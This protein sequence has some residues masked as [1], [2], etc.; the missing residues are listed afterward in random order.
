MTTMSTI[1]IV[2]IA[3]AILFDFLNGIHDSSNIV[4]TMISSRAFSPRVALGVTAV[5]EFAGPFI[6]GVAVATTIGDEVVVAEAITMNVL[7]AALLSAIIWNLLTWFFGIPSSS[8]HALIGGMVGAVGVGA[9]WDAIKL[10]GIEKIL[11]ALFISP[12]LGLALGYLFTKLVF[13]FARGASPKIN[14]FFRRSQIVT[15]IAL[16]LSHGT[17]DAQKTMGLI[18]LGLVTAGAIPRFEVPLWV[19]AVSAGAISLGTALGGWRLIKTLGA[20][21]YKIRPVHGFS[22][23]VTS[24]FVILGASMI[25]GPVS[26]TQVVSS[27]IM[28]VGSAERVSMVRWGVAKDI[29]IAWIVTIPVTAAMAAGLFWVVERILA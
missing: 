16:A 15:A 10:Q 8:S 19:I 28:G 5:A 24:A 23:Q 12:L 26:T 11:V 29:I 17:N 25:G 21:F 18:T 2:M 27:S 9:G 13:F 14:N 7:L 4:A 22:S 6:F 20:K 3:L 1:L